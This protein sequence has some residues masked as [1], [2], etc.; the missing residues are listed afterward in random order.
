MSGALSALI[1]KLHATS[2][3]TSLINA[4]AA[5]ARKSIRFGYYEQKQP[6]P[7]V[8]LTLEGEERESAAKEWGGM[9]HSD[10]EIDV[11]G[12]S[13]KQVL[14]LKSAI[15]DTLHKWSDLT[16]TPKVT[17]CEVEGV[18]MLEKPEERLHICSISVTIT[19]LGT[20]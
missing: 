6:T 10:V 7:F 19:T 17:M 15:A 12:T 14:D 13:V 4:T 2:A 16:L 8:G 1:T 18:T 5:T 3:V 11:W 9:L 20:T